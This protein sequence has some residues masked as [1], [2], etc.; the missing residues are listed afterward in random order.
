M[1]Y[2]GDVA[3]G[4]FVNCAIKSEGII[5]K[6]IVKK[7]AGDHLQLCRASPPLVLEY[8]GHEGEASSAFDAGSPVSTWALRGVFP[9]WEKASKSR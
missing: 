3:K 4:V 7:N 1:H 9:V 8:S 2:F 5:V 6:I